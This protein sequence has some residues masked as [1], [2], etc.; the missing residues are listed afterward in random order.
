[1]SNGLSPETANANGV[2]MK[3]WSYLCFFSQGIDII[4]RPL[5]II[6]KRA[7]I[8]KNAE[9]YMAGGGTVASKEKSELGC[10]NLG[11]TNI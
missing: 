8:Q 6:Q 10:Q 9:F 4:A 7:L 2:V 11:T 1:M 5:E 3:P